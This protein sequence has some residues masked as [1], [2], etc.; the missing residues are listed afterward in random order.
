LV[1]LLGA[2][3]VSFLYFSV[4]RYLFP[5]VNSIRGIRKIAVPERDFIELFSGTWRDYLVPD[6]FHWIFPVE[7]N[8]G[9]SDR[10]GGIMV[11]LPI[12]IAQD[13]PN[14]MGIIVALLFLLA[15]VKPIRIRLSSQIRAL[16]VVSVFLF[17]L[18][19]KTIVFGSYQ[20]PVPSSFLKFLMPGLR[21]FS[22][23]ALLA[24]VFAVIVA[25]AC[26]QVCASFIE[27]KVYSKILVC[28][29]SALVLLDFHPTNQRRLFDD[30]KLVHDFNSVIGQFPFGGVLVIGDIPEGTINAPVMNSITNDDWKYQ[31]AVQSDFG[32]KDLAAYLGEQNIRFVVT[33]EP[34]SESITRLDSE[35]EWKLDFNNPY[36]GKLKS[37]TVEYLAPTGV[38]QRKTISLFQVFPPVGYRSCFDCIPLETRV[39]FGYVDRV[40]S[41]GSTNWVQVDRLDLII[42]SPVSKIKK[43]G[44]EIELESPFG[45]F[46]V[47]RS[48]TI[49]SGEVVLPFEVLPGGSKIKIAIENGSTISITT[50]ES[51][52]IPSELEEGNPDSRC[53]LYGIKSI[54]GYQSST[55]GR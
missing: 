52:V 51:C 26:V 39:D 34:T 15:F 9:R 2:L 14:Y 20:I 35:I 40:D 23:F 21:V 53:L 37:V 31:I 10:W 36:F 50:T 11:D 22:R 27:K 18:S 28:F 42:S 54:R 55:T 33:E 19:I 6:R 44:V 24:E 25:F 47:P 3:A 12:G 4:F 41:A 16:S 8:A 49:R 17:S 32:W 29:I 38:S 30:F 5:A 7:W 45:G 13:L 48:V 43:I 46:A 1:L